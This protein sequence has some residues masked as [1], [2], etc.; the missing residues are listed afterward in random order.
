MYVDVPGNEKVQKFTGFGIKGMDT[1][2]NVYGQ[3]YSSQWHA[4]ATL[5]HAMA[6]NSPKNGL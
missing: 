1:V 5:A 2:S 3:T 6:H 4:C